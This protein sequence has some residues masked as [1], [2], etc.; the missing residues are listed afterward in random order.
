[1][2]EFP[3]KA[4]QFKEGSVRAVK[5]GSKGGK[6]VTEKRLWSQRLR[7]MREKG[8]TDET[9][10][11]LYAMMTE[12]K[13][14]AMDSLLKIEAWYSECEDLKDKAMLNRLAQDVAKHI[15]PNDKP[16][17]AIQNNIEGQGKIEINV[18][19]Y[20]KTETTN[21]QLED[22][23]ETTDGVENTKRQRDD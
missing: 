7:R 21:N 22:V 2:G 12:K 10:Q 6:V 9:Y 3:N 4:T 23:H 17:I 8:M 15:H 18:I 5:S 13:S 16:T 19:E 1:M 20:G 14:F 11:R